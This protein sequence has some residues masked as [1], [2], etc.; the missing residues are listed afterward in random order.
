[1][2]ARG[3]LRESPSLMVMERLQGRGPRLAYHDPYVSV[4]EMG[5]RVVNRTD[6]SHWAIARADCVALLTPHSAYDLAW[7]ADRAQLVFDARNAYG[8]DRRA[9]VERL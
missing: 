4:L 9:N 6:M 5:G 1:M 2:H 8:P 3:D 7:I